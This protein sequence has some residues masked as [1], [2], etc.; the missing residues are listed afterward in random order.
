MAAALALAA[1]R[2]GSAGSDAL[3]VVQR[4]TAAFN[5]SNVDAIV[6]LYA[7]DALFFGTGSR[8][9]VTSRDQIRSYFDAAL[10]KDQPRGAQ[11]LDHSVQV[12]SDRVVIVTGLDRVSGTKNGSVYHSDGRVTFV[13]ERRGDSWQ[14]VHFH[15]S[16]LP[17]T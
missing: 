2:T 9:L 14:I 5:E 4:W 10:K 8:S 6:S 16:A 7:P 1:C 17:P 12:L 13:I 11:L 15:R 3:Q